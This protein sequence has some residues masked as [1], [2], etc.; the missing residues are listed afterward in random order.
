[1]KLLICCLILLI[2]CST[3]KGNQAVLKETISSFDLFQKVVSEG[4]DADKTVQYFK[5]SEKVLVPKNERVVLYIV[6]DPSTGNQRWSIAYENNKLSSVT[7][8]PDSSDDS[9]K[10][11]SLKKSW[12]THNCRDHLEKKITPHAI[13]EERFL[14]CIGRS[15]K[16]N[17]YG[18]TEY[19]SSNLLQETTGPNK[20]DVGFMLVEVVPG[21]I[22]QRLGLKNG[23]IIKKMNGITITSIDFFSSQLLKIKNGDKIT[24]LIERN[25]EEKFISY[26][27]E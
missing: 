17:L 14:I 6:R 22:Y 12:A 24:L 19:I 23:D 9:F 10:Y 1:M 20:G 7:Y 2:S 4:W 13:V 21:S 16:F 26:T 5:N 15:A 25:G 11:A 3:P 8:F 27:I 18:E